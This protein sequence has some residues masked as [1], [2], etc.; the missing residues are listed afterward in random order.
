MNLKVIVLFSSIL[1]ALQANSQYDSR[2]FTYDENTK[3]YINYE[4]L[5][6]L[7]TK[8]LL[9][10]KS[11]VDE[12]ALRQQ[13]FIDKGQL[14]YYTD[15][16]MHKKILAIPATIPM[17]FHPEVG[18]IIRY[19][20]YEKRDYMTRM[21]TASK[22]YF[23]IFEEVLDQHNLPIELKYLAIVESA[24][25]PQARSRVGATGLWQ[26]M[27]GTAKHEGMEI[28]SL[29]D[30]RSDIYKSTEHAAI[31]LKKLYNIY[32]DWLLALAAYNSGPGNVNKA[33]RNSGG[34]DFWSIKHRLPRETQNYV[35]SFIAIAYAMHYAKEYKLSP[36]K[37][38]LNFQAC[39]IEKVYDKQSLKYI[40]EL[41]GCT[42]EHLC[43][44][45]PAL[46][47]GIIPKVDVGY[48]L[49]MPKELALKFNEKRNLLAL[50]P[51]IYNPSFTPPVTSEELLA[52]NS[53]PEPNSIATAANI[54]SYNKPSDDKKLSLSE[55]ATTL[56]RRDPKAFASNPVTESETNDEEE[57]PKKLSTAS[58]PNYKIVK[59]TDVQKKTIYHKVRKGE[60]LTAIA[61]KYGVSLM[62]LKEWN[63]I[64][65]QSNLFVGKKLKV[66]QTETIVKPQ[67]A[68]DSKTKSDDQAVSAVTENVLVHK[69]R[70]GETLMQLTRLYNCSIN[71]LK[72]WNNL[73]STDVKVD[74]EIYVYV[75]SNPKFKNYTYYEAKPGD[76]LVTASIQLNIPVEVLKS[77]NN[78]G[79]NE[80]LKKGE[81][82][83]IPT[84]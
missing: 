49:V 72:E 22:T 45:N 5:E 28:N 24:L 30:E 26:F 60:N 15:E 6:E 51:Y 44:Y 70:R 3:N 43:K 40:S 65:S 37:P 76:T 52:N 14:P 62:D 11:V 4:Q 75:E 20:L 77:L 31:Y 84:L 17:K 83:K 46:K 18:R 71:D 82:I 59:V 25:N 29:V 32:G 69:I 38:L 81:K 61:N 34:Y 10:D 78:K 80:P 55:I 19:F 47:K 16:E 9:K 53:I 41:I 58:S 42:E 1:Y 39:K 74:Q 23:P 56:S 54:V 66:E 33:I 48:G 2:N 67:F 63:D 35:P 12:E 68:L 73:K 13:I 79:E 21:L 8:F 36:G 57:E 50:D 64:S 7:T 27:H